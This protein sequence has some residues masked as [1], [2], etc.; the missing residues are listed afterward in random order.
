MNNQ[1]HAKTRCII[2][3]DAGYTRADAM[4]TKYCC[5]HFARGSCHQGHE[6][7]FLHRLPLPSRKSRLPTRVFS[8]ADLAPRSDELPDNALD[9]FGR[10]KG[11]E[12][13]DDMSG[14]GS[15]SKQNLTLYVG[16]I[17]DGA[18][19]EDTEETVRRHFGEWGDIARSESR[20]LAN[21]TGPCRSQ[22]SFS[23]C[24]AQPRCCLCHLHHRA[25]SA[26]RQGSHVQPESRRR[27]GP[28]RTMGY[29]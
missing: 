15:F 10:E 19:K 8:L 24:P 1:V 5:I 25:P 4:G 28:E 2:A 26:I 9:C 21:M 17:H 29:R 18:R 7:K 6:C 23:K 11:A 22:S 16:K 3:R 20:L 14:V 12:Y 27:R 13:R